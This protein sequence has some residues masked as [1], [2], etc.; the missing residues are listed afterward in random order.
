M[1]SEKFSI[2]NARK[3]FSSAEYSQGEGKHG[4]TSA[5]VLRAEKF[6]IIESPRYE[7]GIKCWLSQPNSKVGKEIV[8]NTVSDLVSALELL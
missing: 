1:E 7:H 8:C 2:E 6:W 3:L 5:K 4:T